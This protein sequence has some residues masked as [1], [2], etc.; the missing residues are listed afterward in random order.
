MGADGRAVPVAPGIPAAMSR[1]HPGPRIRHTGNPR[2]DPVAERTTRGGAGGTGAEP[3]ARTPAREFLHELRDVTAQ[4]DTALIFDEVVTGFRVHPGGARALFGVRADIATYGKV[5][6]GGLP[7]GVVAGSAKYLDALDG[8]GWRFGD[9]SCPEAGVTF[10]AGTFVRHPLTRRRPRGAAAPEQDGPELRRGLSLR[11]TAFVRRLT[12]VVAE[13]GV[14]VQVNH[15]SSWFVVSFPQDLPLA[16]VYYPLMREKGVY[17]SEGRACF[18]TLAHSDADLDH[19]VTAFR[20]TL[21]EMQAAGFL[22]AAAA[23]PRSAR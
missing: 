23:S 4:S 17:A 11:T 10:F 1:E 15:F 14:P 19:I 9:D 5:V 18:L 12:D 3:P 22:P 20:A 21:T 8:G 2:D 13:L 16:P 7:I 6:G